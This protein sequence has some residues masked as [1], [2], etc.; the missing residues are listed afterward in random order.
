MKYLIG[1]APPIVEV[2]SFS[3][4]SAQSSCHHAGGRFERDIAWVDWKSGRYESAMPRSSGKTPQ[5]RWTL[6]C[7]MH[8]T[9]WY[10]SLLSG[11]IGK[12]APTAQPWWTTH[13]SP[14]LSGRPD[15]LIR[16]NCRIVGMTAA[17]C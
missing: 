13:S 1:M 12:A 4:I 16:L 5:I 14:G 15:R 3:D 2:R 9:H 17:V 10:R 11:M 8:Q 6:C 7:K